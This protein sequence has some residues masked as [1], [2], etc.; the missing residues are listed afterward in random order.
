MSGGIVLVID[1]EVT[2]IEIL[3][4]SLEPDCE[5][6]FATN[7]ADGIRLA[8]DHRP[9]VILLDVVMPDMNGYAVFAAL[10][11]DPFTGS[12]PVIFVTGCNEAEDETYGLELGA[13]DYLSKPLRPSVVRVRVRNQLELRR[14]RDELSR[15]AVTDALTGLANRRRFDEALQR[16]FLR[17]SRNERWLS[18]LLLDV[19]YFK[20]FNDHYGHIAGDECLRRIGSILAVGTKRAADLVARYGGE[21]FA[22]ILPDTELAGALHVAEELRSAVAQ[23]GIEH[24]RS[25][26]APVVTISIGVGAETCSTAATPLAIVNAADRE[27]YAAKGAGRNQTRP[28]R[29]G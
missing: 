24:V 8:L 10:K 14:T 25:E 9:D 18:V 15:Q 27:L 13:A 1:D 4:A 21:E 20:S 3:A 26:I 6:I 19:D 7:G 11:E 5:V 2:N 29:S 23:L 17:L 22:V 12:I 16:E 28:A